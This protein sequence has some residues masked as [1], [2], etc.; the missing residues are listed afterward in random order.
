MKKTTSVLLLAGFFV[1][2][3]LVACKKKSADLLGA[4]GSVSKEQVMVWA[5]FAEPQSLDPAIIH[6]SAANAV[7]MQLFEGLTEFDPKTSQAIPAAA[8]RWEVSPDGKTYTFYLH[9]NAKWSDGHPLTADDF[10]Y[11]WRRV[12]APATAANYA[13]MAFYVKNGEA[14]SQSKASPEQLGVKALDEHTLQVELERPTAFFPSIAAF[15][16]LRPTPRWVIE[17]YGD[18]WTRPEHMVSNGF[19]KL[20]EW[21][22]QKNIVMVPNEHYW[23]RAQIKLDKV[24]FLPIE[25]QE[26]SLKKAM[27]G[28]IHYAREIPSIKIPSLQG[29]PNFQ[30]QPMLGTY[31]IMLNTTRKPLNDINVR[32]ALWLAID[33]KKLMET[34]KMG[35]ANLSLTPQGVGSYVPPQGEDFDLVKAR[36][37][38][39]KAGFS[40]PKTFPKLV[41]T[42]NTDSNHKMNM[43]IVQSM[44]RQNLGIDVEM[45]NVEWKVLLQNRNMLDYDIQRAGWYGDYLDPNTFLDLMLTGGGNNNTGWSN[46]K[47]DALIAQ[48]A[49]SNDNAVRWKYFSE[50]E[51][52]VL[53]EAP[54]IPLYTYT[55]PSWISTQLDGFY[56]NLIDMHP[57]KGVS[58]K[59][60]P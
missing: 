54:I 42:Y 18:D 19:F 30:M 59:A 53:D 35:K 17:Q 2:C 13:Y 38:L 34:V 47:Y 36:E 55:L 1:L 52:I 45:Q 57:L 8:E 51:K 20:T 28:E 25:D 43:E 58:L 16:T 6:D 37:Y 23:D 12:V 21:V 49:N 32:K 10:V 48:A 7:A 44:W 50:A 9:P 31:F 3:G 24:I 26:T 5:N 15:L 11:S 4:D 46:A 29:N 39:A 41:L 56:T 40:D 33:R 60:A 22:P 27:A 14:I